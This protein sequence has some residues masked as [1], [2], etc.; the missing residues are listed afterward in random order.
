M[1]DGFDPEDIEFVATSWRG[2][3]EFFH[4]IHDV[5][6]DLVSA[7]LEDDEQADLP[8]KYK[9]ASEIESSHLK[10]GGVIR[11]ESRRLRKDLQVHDVLFSDDLWVQNPST[12]SSIAFDGRIEYGRAESEKR[13]GMGA[14][15]DGWVEVWRKAGDDRFLMAAEI[16]R[17]HFESK[18][19][20][21]LRVEGA[22]RTP[23]GKRTRVTALI[24]RPRRCPPT[25]ASIVREVRVQR[26]DGGYVLSQSKNPCD[27]CLMLQTDGASE[28]ELVCPAIWSGA[29]ANFTSR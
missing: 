12:G 1:E 10:M 22:F 18:Q 25:P 14:S 21:Q 26:K 23:C 15:V 11:I 4:F 19:L 13:S 20:D 3:G 2:A 16:Q 27:D 29:R 7:A 6:P 8:T 5:M 17:L 24:Q 9:Q 28:P